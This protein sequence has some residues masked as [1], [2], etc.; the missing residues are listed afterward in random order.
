M[1]DKF[2]N[3]RENAKFYIPLSDDEKIQMLESLGLKSEGELFSHIPQDIRADIPAF[4]PLS[5]AE[6]RELIS[7]IARKNKLPQ[8]SFLGDGAG[9][10]QVSKLAAEI[11]RIR[12][13]STAYTP[14]QP[15]RSQGTLISHWIY[16]CLMAQLTGFEAVNCSLYDGATALYEAI[17]CALRLAKKSK[18]LVCGS[19]LPSYLKVVHTLAKDAGIEIAEVPTDRNSGKTSE[20]NLKNALLKNP[21]AAC[22][23]FP[24]INAFGIIEDCDMLADFAKR[25]NLKSVAVIDP[26]LLAPNALKE[27]AMYGESGADIAV[28]EARHLYSRPNLGGLGLGIFAIR[29]NSEHK[30]DIRQAPGRFVGKAKDLNSKDCFAMV[31]STREQ[32]IRFEKATSNICS[33]EAFMVTLAGACLLEKSDSGLEESAKKARRLAEIAFEKI[34]SIPGFSYPFE[35]S[36][37]FNEFTVSCPA[38]VEEIIKKAAENKIHIGVNASGRCGISGELLKISL[39]DKNS[40]AQIEAACEFLRGFAGK[41]AQA[42]LSRRKAP[43]IPQSFTRASSPNIPKFKGEEILAYYEKLGKLNISPDYACYPLG[44][45]TMKYNPLLNDELAAL[46]GFELAHPQ[47]PESDI[48]GSLEILW[49]FQELIKKITS[50]DA[51]AS[52]PVAGAQGELCALKMIQAYQRDNSPEL[53]DTIL[54]P[55]SAHGTNFASAAMAGFANIVRIAPDKDGT[56]SISALKEKLELFE[57]RVA[58]IMITNPNTSGIF[59]TRFREIADLVHKAGGLVFMDGANFNAIAGQ[60]DLKKMGVDAV[61]NNLHKTWSIS[62]GGGGPGDAFVAVDEKLKDYIPQYIVKNEGG[63]FKLEPPRKS[64]GSLHAFFGNF[65]HKV[66]ALSYIFRLGSDGVK[67]MS[68]TAVLASRYLFKNLKKSWLTLPEA[69]ENQPRMHEFILTIADE[70][71]RA[72]EGAEV[73]RQLAISRIGKAFLDYGFHAPTVSFPEVFG[74]MIEPT[75]S[76][77]KAEL[78]RFKDAVNSIKNKIKKAPEKIAASPRF[79]PILRIDETSA[80]RSPVFSERLEKLPEIPELKMGAEDF[81]NMSISELEAL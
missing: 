10:W 73:P 52:Q 67:A 75:E 41:E 13:L 25:N 6:T 80:N 33:N 21:D 30:N 2:C 40:E 77:T 56:L 17:A 50:L 60:V 48:Q 5:E 70:D 7:G 72:L 79:M 39:S 36:P 66:R 20:E 51:L 28:G 4:A 18:A 64:I 12:G 81:L 16:Q 27:P 32:H 31:L 62:H 58:A 29:H 44:S 14:Y 34:C 46:D 3:L 42:P 49:R 37:F 53:R 76:Y 65:P 11:S 68:Q 35:N 23:A 24:Q 59:E 45:C 38:R 22:L 1:S 78:D 54:I 69:C 63:V 19:I 57:G 47:A 61:H 71:F 55:Q 74:L 9:D 43:E 15:E 8:I 26:M